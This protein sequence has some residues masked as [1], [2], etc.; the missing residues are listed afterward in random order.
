MI[1]CHFYNLDRSYFVGIDSSVFTH[2][3]RIVFRLKDQPMWV[4]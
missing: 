1:V 3:D 4:N 2:W